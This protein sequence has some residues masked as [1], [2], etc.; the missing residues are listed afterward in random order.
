M[1]LYPR[2]I[3]NK[4]YV[5]TRK[6]GYNPPI[7][8]DERVR[9]I[10]IP[11]GK[12]YECRKQY[13]ESWRVR[14][15][16]EY[17]NK[18][19]GMFVTMTISDEYYDKL[20]S[21]CMQEYSEIDYNKMAKIAIRRCLERYRKK[22]KVSFKHWFIPELGKETN[23]LHIHGII[24]DKFDIND[25]WMY[26]MT[27]TGYVNEASIAYVV[28]YIAKNDE[29]GF[30][31]RV[32]CSAGIGKC[33][34]DKTNSKRNEFKPQGGTDLRYKYDNNHVG[35]I[36]KYY[37]DKLYTDKQR[38]QLMIISQITG[39][40]YVMGQCINIKKDYNTY[41]NVLNYERL[42]M[43]RLG[44]DKPTIWAETEEHRK[45]QIKNKYKEYCKYGKYYNDNANN[46]Q[47]EYHARAETDYYVR[48]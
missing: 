36:P 26:G 8:E 2:E 47:S 9:F 16:E 46:K 14:M 27:F 15:N 34:L 44:F 33:Y 32:F 12:C 39:V 35:M 22:N 24:F 6:N 37:K 23:R 30:K 45:N 29:N 5:P 38:E 18:R 43:I 20:E 7:C 31:G 41:D 42:R 11:C 13:A 17:R 28:K 4:R 40:K 1:C 10:T 3:R 25:Y 48:P 19:V 21:E